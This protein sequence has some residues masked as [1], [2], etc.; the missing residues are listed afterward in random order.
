ME[1]QIKRLLIGGTIAIC[2]ALGLIFLA[3][4]CSN[5]NWK[6]FSLKPESK[7][8]E[9]TFDPNLITEMDVKTINEAINIKSSSDNKIHI[10]Y[11]ESEIETYQITK[12]NGTLSVHY[13]NLQSGLDQFLSTFRYGILQ[14]D[15]LD[16]D[17]TIYLPETYQKTLNVKDTN[18]SVTVEAISLNELQLNSV[19]GSLKVNN[20]N[21]ETL[22]MKSTNGAIQ[23]EESDTK[24]VIL[25]STNGSIKFLNS[26]GT[27]MNLNTTNGSIKASLIGDQKEYNIKVSKV[28]G[29]S[30]IDNQVSYTD[31]QLVVSSINGSINITFKKS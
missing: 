5:F 12:Q 29:S 9:V 14:F 4:V 21:M 16:R 18:G 24:N 17:L 31:Q 10:S 26:S 22:N 1:K 2:V 6:R 30:N 7:L 28:N 3:L 15:W 13:E 11:Y 25:K 8:V 19:N 23:V 27:N 20:S